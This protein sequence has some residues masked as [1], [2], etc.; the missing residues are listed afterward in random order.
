[1]QKPIEPHNAPPPAPIVAAV[2][3]AVASLTVMANAT[4]APS[5]PGLRETF[6]ATPGVTTLVGLVMTLPSLSI[7]LTAAIAGTIADKFGRRP[8]MLFSL[9]VYGLAGAS[10]IVAQSL[11]QL[12]LGRIL[13]GMAVGGTMTS[14]LALIGDLFQ[15]K[16]RERMISLQA[17]VMSGSGVLFLLA[18]GALG[19][20]GWRYPFLVYLIALPLIPLV[21][22]QITE[23]ERAPVSATAAPDRLPVATL[24]LVGGVAMITMLA[25]YVT[26]TKMPFLLLDLGISSPA[27]V[28]VT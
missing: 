1:M 15:G 22:M 21:L 23:P 27:L 14:A 6:K 13:L 5:L 4:I 12:L 11:G 16:A 9:V 24:V 20:L 18:G 7:V 25:F 8:V 3:L 17:A 28:G 10:G 2:L 26:P 19:E